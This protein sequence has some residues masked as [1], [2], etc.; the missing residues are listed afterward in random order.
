M[1]GSSNPEIKWQ[2]RL[3]RLCEKRLD[4]TMRTATSKVGPKVDI[5]AETK[6]LF[7]T[8][9]YLGLAYH[10]DIISAIQDAAER[11]GTGAGA[12]RLVSGNFEIHDVLE[13]AAARYVHAEAAVLFVSGYQANVGAL[14]ALTGKGDAIFS[15]E[16]VH[17]SLI[18]GARLSRA[19]VY[20]FRHG[21]MGHLSRLLSRAD[22]HQLKLIVTDAIFSMDGDTAKLPDITTL[23]RKHNAAIYLDEA[24]ALGVVGPKG[25]GL[26]AAYGLSDEIDI[27]IAT[28]SKALGVSGA[29]VAA[30]AT[31]AALIRSSARSLLFTTAPSPVIAAAALKSLGIAEKAAELREKLNRNIE[32]FKAAAESAKLP[33]LD[34]KTAIQPIITGDNFRTMAV[35]ERLFDAGFWVQGIRPPT[36]PPGKGRLRVTLSAKQDEACIEALVSAIQNAL[37]AVPK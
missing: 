19:D 29:F 24:H 20:V 32:F 36:V 12:S 28:F 30:S 14:S 34:S 25:R 16:L 33:L 31:V 6:Y 21:D 35:S 9:D 2:N 1:I 3:M 11:W 5:G 37:R 23:A 7:C 26:A 17:A 4:R 18:D 22:P 8:N 15:D 27:R 13:C 10:P